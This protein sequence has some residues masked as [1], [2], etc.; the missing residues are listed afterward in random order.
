MLRIPKELALEL[1]MM[2]WGASLAKMGVTA[3]GAHE[4][5]K[6]FIELENAYAELSERYDLDVNPEGK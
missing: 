4:L 3:N 2:P 6:A 1:A 5:G